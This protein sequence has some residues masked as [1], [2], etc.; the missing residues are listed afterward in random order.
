VRPTHTKI[1]T[2]SLYSPGL[3]FLIAILWAGTHQPITSFPNIY[4][5]GYNLYE[6]G[7]SIAAITLYL[8]DFYFYFQNQDKVIRRPFCVFDLYGTSLSRTGASCDMTPELVPHKMYHV[9]HMYQPSCGSSSRLKR[10]GKC[11]AGC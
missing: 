1:L 5:Q 8:D 7:L 2:S 4:R 11:I 9:I 3:L 10:S 6:P